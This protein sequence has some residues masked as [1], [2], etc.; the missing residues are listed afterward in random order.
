MGGSE[1][2]LVKLVSWIKSHQ[3]SERSQAKSSDS[4]SEIKVIPF[5]FHIQKPNLNKENND[6]FSKESKQCVESKHKLEPIIV[7]SVT[8]VSPRRAKAM[9]VA[10]I[11]TSL[12]LKERLRH[13]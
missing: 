2:S 9:A 7:Q 3:Q 6:K 8:G 4:Q 13:P 5:G 10:N 1:P 12:P 11:M